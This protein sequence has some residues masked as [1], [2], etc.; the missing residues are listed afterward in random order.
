[1][2]KNFHIGHNTNRLVKKLLL[3]KL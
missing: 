3:L 2:R 1:L